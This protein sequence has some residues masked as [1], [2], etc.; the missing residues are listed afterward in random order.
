MCSILGI[1]HSSTSSV[2]YDR[3][4]SFIP[5]DQKARVVSLMGRAEELQYRFQQANRTARF[6][7]LTFD[8]G[9]GLNDAVKNS[10]EA[11]AYS[12][13]QHQCFRSL[14]IDICACLLDQA[15]NIS[16]IKKI[17]EDLS[18]GKLIDDLKAYHGERESY[19]VHVT[20]AERDLTENEVKEFTD[21]L[22]DKHQ[23]RNEND[24]SELWKCIKKEKGI[25]YG[26][27]ANRLKWARDNV[28]AHYPKSEGR[29]LTLAD[30][31]PFDGGAFTWIEPIRF[32][33][34]VRSLAYDVFTLITWTSWGDDWVK[35]DK[36]YAMAF[37]GRFKNGKANLNS[38]VIDEI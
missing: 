20:S 27:R 21:Y 7:E 33:D 38:S 1:Q 35:H 26:A 23:K 11:H 36:F 14:V 22:R 25:L 6:L 5:A 3:K 18:N 8:P 12:S 9:M 15:K 32:L 30:E 19:E 2:N 10:Y 34:D 29:L 13:L 16:S 31:P 28:L 37:W 24:V 17:I 4:G